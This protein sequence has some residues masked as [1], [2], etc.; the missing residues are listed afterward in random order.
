MRHLKEIVAILLLLA[1]AG[2]VYV[3]WQ[4]ITGTS[5]EA[6]EQPARTGGGDGPVF[7]TAP[8]IRSEFETLVEAVGSTRA[9]Q[10]VEITP[11]SSGRITEINFHAGKTV[12]A[13]D[14][15]LRLD[16]DIQRADMVESEA[17]LGEAT[18]ALE[19]SRSLMKS[20]ATS[21]A[22]VE[23]LVADLATA[24]ATRVRAARRMRDR[25]VSAPPSIALSAFPTSR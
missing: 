12:K 3:G 23:K 20:S 10:A 18:R 11:T 24:G 1:V 8:V 21:S 13:G 19:R 22:A 17:Q 9:R 25:V 14:D 7:E 5:D 6:Q 2:G 16:D 4:N 15:L